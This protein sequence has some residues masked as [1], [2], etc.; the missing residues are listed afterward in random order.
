MKA[1]AD[2]APDANA[3][4]SLAE[5]WP[6][7]ARTTRLLNFA[8]SGGTLILFLRP[9]LE[10]TWKKLPANRR[11][12][13]AAML[14]SEPMATSMA[15]VNT[16]SVAAE[17]DPLVSGFARDKFDDMIVRR[18]VPFSADPQGTLLL[19]CYPKD[20]RP[21]MRASGLLYRRSVGVGT[22]YTIATLPD[23][24]YTNIE[25]HPLFLPLLVRMAQRPLSCSSAQNVEIGQ[26]LTLIG[27]QF[28]N[29]PSMTLEGPQNDTTIVKAQR[30]M[31]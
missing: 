25:F 12:A 30:S 7:D 1:A 31:A 24:Q 10:E 29:F 8:R 11:A 23:R 20:P 18:V 22:V 9:G 17:N 4:V 16:V 13:L 26:P 2:I 6:D 5:D 15:P 27:R 14:P 19:N 21:G 3:A 28:E